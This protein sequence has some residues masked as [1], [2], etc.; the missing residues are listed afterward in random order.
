[1]SIDGDGELSRKE[2]IRF[3]KLAEPKSDAASND[4]TLREFQERARASANNLDPITGE[5]ILTD[6]VS[7]A[8]DTY[9]SDQDGIVSK[10]ELLNWRRNLLNVAFHRHTDRQWRRPVPIGDIITALSSEGF[11]RQASMA[12]KAGVVPDNAI[13]RHTGL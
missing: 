7:G 8:F 2:L 10:Q 12:L 1:M 5:P 4:M 6:S 11:E 3:V 9:D 13:P